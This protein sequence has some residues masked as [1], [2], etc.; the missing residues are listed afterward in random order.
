MTVVPQHILPGGSLLSTPPTREAL[1]LEKIVGHLE[2]VEQRIA[3]L[4]AG[5]SGGRSSVEIKTLASGAP[6]LTVKI[7]A[8]SPAG[9]VVDEA[10]FEWRRAMRELQGGIDG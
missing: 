9:A 4:A 1:L 10:L 8:D 5:E 7:Y 3:L 2:R 6:Q